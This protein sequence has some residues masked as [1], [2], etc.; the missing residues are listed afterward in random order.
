MWNYIYI[1]DEESDTKIHKLVQ[2]TTSSE[3]LSLAVMQAN[4]HVCPEMCVCVYKYI[5]KFF[6]FYFNMWRKTQANQVQGWFCRK[7]FTV[8]SN[9]TFCNDR[10]ALYTHVA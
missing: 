5:F 4:G 9:K 8:L 2:Q 10:N 7:G 6:I 3:K 1:T